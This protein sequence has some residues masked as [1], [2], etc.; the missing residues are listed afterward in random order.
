MLSGSGAYPSVLARLMWTPA[1]PALF[2]CHKHSKTQMPKRWWLFPLL[3]LATIFVAAGLFVGFAIAVAYPK[4]PSL[5]ALAE[6]SPKLPM[7]IFSAEGLLISEFGEERRAVVK[8]VE[9]PVTLRQAILAA[10]D[11][12]FYEHGGIDYVGILRALVAN[13]ATGET[14]QGA[15]T[16]TMQVARNF[17]LSSERTLSRKF[18]EALLSFKIEHSLSKD[19][20]LALYINQIYLGQRA[21][22]FAAAAQAYFGKKLRDLSVAQMAMLA[23]LPKAPSKFNPVVNLQRAT[24]RQRYVLRRMRELNYLNEPQYQQALA[25]ELELRKESIRASDTHADYFNEMVRQS[26]FDQYKDKIYTHGIRVFTT[27]RKADQD[28]AYA[29][30]R[31]GVM[32]YDRRHGYRGPEGSKDL[33]ATLDSDTLD[34]LLADHS[35]S[36][37]LLAA[38]VTEVSAQGLTA[39][40]R[41]QEDAVAVSAE[42][43]KLIR[44]HIG[45]KASAATR[46][47]RGAI[48]RVRRN[49]KGAW[50]VAQMPQVEAA[51]VALDS[52][53]GAIRA[54]VGGF[55]FE[56]NKFNHVSQGQRQPGS[57]FKPFVYSAALEKGYSA[58]TLFNDAPLSFDATETG[59]TAWEPKNYDGTF[60]G[61]MRMRSALT[62][63]KN[64]VSIRIIRAI[65]PEY[66]QQ[67][68][69]RFGFDARRHPPYLTMA[70]GAGS[71]TPLELAAGYCVFANG[72]YRVAPYFVARVE[73]ATGK[74][75]VR[76]MPAQAGAGA[77]RAI[78]PRNAFI[79]FNMMQDVIR[80]GTGA[81]ALQLGR[82]DIAGK[83]GTTN[84]QTDAWFAGIQEQV[85]AVAWMGFDSPRT[86]GSDETGSK[87][88]LP[89]WI[90]YM[91]D[92][93]KRVPVASPSIPAGVVSARVN[94]LTGEPDEAG[95]LEYFY[96][97]HVPTPAA[98]GETDGSTPAS[99]DQALEESR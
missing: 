11:E 79:M 10:E 45:D 69:T 59:S 2:P 53:S 43:L 41:T 86:L 34:D 37:D 82:P 46:V 31:K 91:A 92:A 58:S 74:V 99:P 98:P 55:D 85:A 18:N 15:S 73:D 70:L 13:F 16:I 76:A 9:V 24:Q 44:N 81:R 87:A 61:M 71:V 97:E 36:D 4:L 19:Q 32:D 14:R 56:R 5:E 29:A 27:L 84:D 21:Y 50:E 64:M 23:G 88:A 60:D 22:G 38:I 17:F 49:D 12:R 77:P 28:A 51:L 89:I 93:L 30:L 66:A 90:H 65:G 35:D 26:L 72:G 57:S 78:D 67:Y 42:G 94:A 96:Q 25:Q 54:L 62:K 1:A 7:R 52:S 75:L 80:A 8:L 40:V 48:I 20:I 83:T 95:V 6:Y 3:A 63:S 47:R 33:P 68:I 39:R